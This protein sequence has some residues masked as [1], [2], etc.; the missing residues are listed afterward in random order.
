MAGPPTWTYPMVPAGSGAASRRKLRPRTLVLAAGLLLAALVA[1]VTVVAVVQTPGFN[2]CR[3]SC[4]PDLGP[5]LLSEE[6]YVSTQFGYRVEYENPFQVSGQ[7]PSGVEFNANTD[8]FMSFSAVSGSN[9]SGAIQRAIS[10]LDSNEFQG[11]HPISTAVA[12]AEIGYI[13]GSGEA[14]SATFVAPGSNTTQA[15]SVVVLAATQADLT[16]SV[17]VVGTQD[18]TTYADIPLGLQ[19][20]PF[21]DFEVSNTIWP[22]G[23]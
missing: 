15:V 19:Y 11:R 5:R 4:G 6:A 12:G 22:G 17:L 9:V 21:F 1:A 18:L 13:P 2:Y 8:N 23:S 3:F 16:I 20:G 7:S 10:G 14:F